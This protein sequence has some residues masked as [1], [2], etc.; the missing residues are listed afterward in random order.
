MVVVT[1]RRGGRNIGG[2]RS[3]R[4]SRRSRRAVVVAAVSFTL[5]IMAVIVH[6]SG[7]GSRGG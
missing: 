1:V 2:C 6:R 7:T 4:G 5:V 3:S